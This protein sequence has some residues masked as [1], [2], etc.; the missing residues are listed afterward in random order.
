[1]GREREQGRAQTGLK[2]PPKL[3]QL[4]FFND[5]LQKQ[6][7]NSFPH[8]GPTL[9][10]NGRMAMEFTEERRYVLMEAPTRSGTKTASR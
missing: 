7:K 10:G 5:I 9:E 1:M 6:K 4:P 2:N 3:P 8:G